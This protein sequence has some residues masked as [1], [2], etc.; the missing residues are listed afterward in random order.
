MRRSLA[1]AVGLVAA[2]SATAQSP[3]PR[4]YLFPRSGNGPPAGMTV[5]PPGYYGPG[6]LFYA[7]GAA[8]SRARPTAYPT[9]GTPALGYPGLGYPGY[10]PGATYGRGGR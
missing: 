9:V 5:S 10:T 1:L 7:G 6:S 8:T 3:E 4:R 2:G